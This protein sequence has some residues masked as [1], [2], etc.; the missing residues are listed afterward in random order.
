MAFNGFDGDDLQAKTLEVSGA[1]SVGSLKV[2]GVA[3][4]ATQADIDEIEVDIVALEAR[5]SVTAGKTIVIA[6]ADNTSTHNYTATGVTAT[7]V[8]VGAFY[9]AN[10][11]D[12]VTAI[13]GTITPGTDIITVAGGA[14]LSSAKTLVF[15]VIL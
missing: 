12:G 2:A 8:V 14:D 11:A 5:K 3:I 4:T 15:T 1:A 10:A 6:G 13:T 7:S 9:V